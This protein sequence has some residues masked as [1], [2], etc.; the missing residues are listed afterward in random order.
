MLKE[1]QRLKSLGFA[2]H[3]LKAN[4]KAPID[5]NW[6]KSVPKSGEQLSTQY[7]K[8]MNM[9]VRF[10]AASKV[11]G[12]YLSAIDCDVKST[13][14]K[15]LEEMNEKL[16][17]L[18]GTQ[19]T[20][21][22]IVLS[23]RGNGS[24]HVYGKT[25]AVERGRRLAQSNEKV[26]VKM[27]SVKPSRHERETLT[28]EELKKGIRLRPAWE[29][30]FMGEG[31]QAVLPPS[32]HPDTGLAYKWQGAFAGLL[33]TLSPPSGEKA[34][35]R[36]NT[37]AGG[38]PFEAVE[39][40]LALTDV[41]ERV[42]K[43]IVDGEGVE[44]RSASLFGVAIALVRSGLSDNEIKSVLTDRSYFLGDTAYDHAKTENRTRAAAWIDRYTLRRARSEMDAQA[45]FE[46]AVEVS[47]LTTEQI[48]DLHEELIELSDWQYLLDRTSPQSGSRP[49]PTLKNILVV[50]RYA[51]SPAVF[52]RNDFTGLEIY[53]TETPWGGKIGG[54]ITDDDM[55]AIKTWLA[56][57]Y[58][59][60]PPVALVNEGVRKIA[61]ENRFHPVRDYLETLKWDGRERIST[62]L[63]TYLNAE[64]AEP[65]LSDVS[66]KVM[67]AL[68]AR[69][70]DPGV[71]FDH[72][73]IL[74]GNQGEG[75]STSLQ[76]LVGDEWFSEL[77]AN[78]GDKDAVLLIRSTWLVEVGELNGLSR[79][80][81]N[82]V[83]DFITRRVDRIRVPYGK[84]TEAFP[85]QCVFVGTTNQDEFLKDETGNRR[86][87][88]VKIGACDFAAVK[89]DRDQL[90][91][92]AVSCYAMGEP[93]Y[94]ENKEAQVGAV[95]EQESR[96][97]S[98]MLED[99]IEAYLASERAKPVKDRHINPDRLTM[100]DVLG[101]WSPIKVG[102]DRSAQIR[103]G[104]ALK[105][106]GY[107]KHV[108]RVEGRNTKVWA[109]PFETRLLPLKPDKGSTKNDSDFE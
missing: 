3:W 28:E 53:G 63:K 104:R 71:K 92:E 29:I 24:M 102:D 51:V 65:Y 62:W 8:G 91:A 73:L 96:M 94:L 25:I 109:L 38:A 97:E 82:T 54:E 108:M 32:L 59:F 20:G 16:A 34:V 80:E 7:R 79:A 14:E 74:Q 26:K 35:Q 60:E 61:C 66:R 10:G 89:R 67:V 49:K 22:P 56:E 9:G 6:T 23:G 42:I 40:D 2:I 5:L 57:K 88:P 52:R 106:L 15:H 4:S 105:R 11:K 101:E 17:E 81:V 70:F 27:P 85:R 39:V 84:R 86:F 50:L 55:I 31:Q 107:A 33:P 58:G 99:Q 69:V 76:N 37:S 75:K 78:I 83:K 44:D 18:F 13:A 64:A 12:G 21:A 87:W 98:D 41:P 103:V 77:Q 68:V 47:D 48:N 19:I 45:Q 43:M 30:S 95:Q 46:E 36:S 72:V 90:L 1:M 93:L 100:S